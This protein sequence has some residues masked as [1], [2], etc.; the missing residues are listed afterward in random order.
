MCTLRI[1]RKCNDHRASS[2]PCPGH[3]LGD[4]DRS[5]NAIPLGDEISLRYKPLCLVFDSPFAV[6]LVVIGKM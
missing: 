3:L 5:L 2:V 1:G 4:L 6:E